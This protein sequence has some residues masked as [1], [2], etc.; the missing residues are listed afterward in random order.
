[1]KKTTFYQL[2]CLHNNTY[3]IVCRDIILLSWAGHNM[4]CCVIWLEIINLFA[5]ATISCRHFVGYGFHVDNDG[6]FI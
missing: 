6:R 5:H 4:R 3:R 1:M 2:C